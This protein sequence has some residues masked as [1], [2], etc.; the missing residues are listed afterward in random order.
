MGRGTDFRG[1]ICGRIWETVNTFFTSVE[2][3]IGDPL[4][5]SLGFSRM[6]KD[7]KEVAVS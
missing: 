7:N 5:V 4:S 1:Y 6:V 3:H 2:F